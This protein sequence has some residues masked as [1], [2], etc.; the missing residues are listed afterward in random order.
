MT[1][2]KLVFLVLVAKNAAIP[3]GFQFYMPDP[4]ARAWKKLD[5]KP[6][7]R[8]VPKKKRLPKPDADGDYP[9]IPEIALNLLRQFKVDHPQIK[10]NCVLA[11]AL[12]FHKIAP[13]ETTS[14]QFRRNR[15]RPIQKIRE[16]DPYR[17]PNCPNSRIPQYDYRDRIPPLLKKR[18]LGYAPNCGQKQAVSHVFRTV[19]DFPRT[20]FDPSAIL[21]VPFP[22]WRAP[23]RPRPG[24]FEKPVVFSS[25]KSEFQSYLG[26]RIHEKNPAG[27]YSGRICLC[28]SNIYELGYE[29][30]GCR[31][32]ALFFKAGH[33]STVSS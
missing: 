6:G 32:F 26:K 8:G 21:P 29:R 30:T 22:P 33:F 4:K 31:S 14:K 13:G 12:L 16:V 28:G 17:C 5:E 15:A 1:G 27:N 24:T 9:R 10:V 25:T 18:T 20:I 23:V 7:R 19:S 2:Q 11:D 3:V